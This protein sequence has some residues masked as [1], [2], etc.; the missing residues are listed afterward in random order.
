MRYLGLLFGVVLLALVSAGCAITDYDGIPGHQT[1]AEAKLWGSEISFLLGD[2]NL[3]GTYSY[4]VKYDNRAGRDPG[5]TIISYRNP[6]DSSFSQDGLVDRDGDDVQ[7]RSGILGGKFSTEWVAVD[8]LPD[9]QFFTNITQDK[10]KGAGPLVALC[11]T[12]QEEIDK[13]KD[14][15]ASFGSVGDLLSQIW[16]GAVSGN[17]TMELTGVKVGGVN[18]P[19]A[20]PVSINARSNGMRPMR[21][22]VDL[23]GANGKALLQT[24]VNNTQDRVPVTFGLNFAGGMSVDLPGQVRV[25]F[26]HAALRRLL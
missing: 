12:F 24:L 8:P 2:P 9:C 7:G 5:M 18:V 6:V 11:A 19:L 17:F 1:Q 20:Q 16:S 26:N 15:Q 14:Q 4:T 25:A 23:T 10:S 13:D 3:D 22:R 21:L